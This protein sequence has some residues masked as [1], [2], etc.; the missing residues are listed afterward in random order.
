MKEGRFANPKLMAALDASDGIVFGCATYMGSGS[1][2]QSG[3]KLST[4]IAACER[5][6]TQHVP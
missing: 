4:R 3:D 1:A 2:S 6:A 5:D